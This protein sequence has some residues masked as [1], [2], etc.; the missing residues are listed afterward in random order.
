MRY[1]AAIG[2]NLDD[3]VDSQDLNVWRTS[4]GQTFTVQDF[5]TWQRQLR[6]SQTPMGA[7]A[8]SQ[9]VPEPQALALPVWCVAL[10]RCGGGR[11]P[12]L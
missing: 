1:R 7:E 3:V 11:G 9:S 4:V 6:N 2:R 5:L 12:R 10:W 8:A